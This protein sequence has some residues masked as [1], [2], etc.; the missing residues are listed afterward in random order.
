VERDLLLRAQAGDAGAIEEIVRTHQGLIRSYVSRLAPDAVTADD[1]AQEVFLAALQSLDRVDPQQGIRGYLLGI[2]RNQ[3]RLAWRAR[4]K[5]SGE[6]LF[7]AM[8]TRGTPAE[9]DSRSDRRV[10][11]LQE[12]LKGLA[13]KALDV[14]LRFYREEQACEEIS[15]EIGTSPSNIRSILT[16]AR[17]ALGECVR[18]RCERSPA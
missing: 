6:A 13:P 11:A 17:Q 10:S 14:V 8:A 3:A 18:L 15:R 7:E 16:R 4:M 5:N 1:L 2:A 9:A 12:C